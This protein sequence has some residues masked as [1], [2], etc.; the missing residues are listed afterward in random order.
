MKTLYTGAIVEIQLK[1]ESGDVVIIKDPFVDR[2][3]NGEKIP[4]IIG[5]YK[6]R[7]E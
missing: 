7:T 3:K 2:D 1:G 5:Y 6:E 4:M